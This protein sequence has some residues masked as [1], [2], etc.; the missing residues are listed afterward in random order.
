MFILRDMPIKRRVFWVIMV[1]SM[2]SVVVG[3]GISMFF[4]VRYRRES[5]RRDLTGLAEMISDNCLVSLEYNIPEDTDKL[6]ASLKRRPSITYA[7]I[8]DIRGNNFANY[9]RGSNMN[10]VPKHD[11]EVTSDG[12]I[13]ADDHLHVWQPIIFEGK[14]IGDLHLFD[15]M[16]DVHQSFRRDITILSIVIVMVMTVAFAMTVSLHSLISNPIADL[17][18]VAK[19]ISTDGDYSLRAEHR[20]GGDIGL[21]VGSFN[22]MLEYI[23]NANREQKSLVHE[24]EEKNIELERFTYTVSHDLKSPLITIKGFVGQLRK[25]MQSGEQER[26]D[27]D[28]NRVEFAAD[29][30]INLLKDL[31]ELSRVGRV[32]GD[33]QTLSFNDVVNHTLPQLEG[34]IQARGVAMYIDDNMPNVTIDTMRFHEV[35][36]NLVEN[37]VKFMGDQK[38]PK[39]S[40]GC[41]KD[42][43][44]NVFFVS[45]NGMGIEEDYREKVFGLFEQLNQNIDGTGI[46]L[47]IVRR[48]VEIHGGSIWAEDGD[49]ESGVT[50]CFTVS[51]TD[52][53]NNE[54]GD[55]N[56]DGRTT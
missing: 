47:T 53:L 22:N 6:L 5:L 32:A 39:I 2:L 8:H 41:R 3:S 45:D 20:T 37:A 21:L 1:T 33:V 24:L 29:K 55:D 49:D 38:K 15:D 27:K 12:H 25:H 50:F 23:E 17:S 19:R 48:I 26:I 42:G 16:S 28:V 14:Q 7:E 4:S 11:A 51:L 40:I 36:Q 35:I 18:G 54:N 34:V 56:N 43:E 52:D 13:T 30:M 44:K 9:H 10:L 31:L 46:G